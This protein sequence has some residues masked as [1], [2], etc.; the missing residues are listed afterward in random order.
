MGGGQEEALGLAAGVA[1][2]FRKDSYAALVD[3][4]LDSQEVFE[5]VG[6]S[7]SRYQVD[8]MACWD[9]RK[10]RDLRVMV[11]IDDGALRTFRPMTTDFII[12]P[13]GSFGGE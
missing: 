4:L 13:D 12:A 9:S 11:N 8:V 6:T 10:R 7:G 2:Q 3:R 5:V 1:E